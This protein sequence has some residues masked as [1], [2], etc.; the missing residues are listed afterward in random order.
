HAIDAPGRD[1]LDALDLLE[2]SVAKRSI[3]RKILSE[4]G[5]IAA[6]LVFLD[7]FGM[8]LVHSNEP[9]W[10]RTKDHGVLAAPA[11]RIAMLVFLTEQQHASLA[12]KLDNLIICI[13]HAH[14]GE[15]LDFRREAARVVNRTIDLQA[16]TLAD[17]E[18]VVT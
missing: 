9:L 17:Y 12:H 11:M 18:V 14:A 7:E 8:R 16:V 5:A 10:C 3:L 4:I 6:V 2:R 13:K 15:I 1:P